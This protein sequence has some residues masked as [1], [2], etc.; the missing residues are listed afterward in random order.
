MLLVPTAPAP[1][2]DAITR[3]QTLAAANDAAGLHAMADDK[4]LDPSVR[5]VAHLRRQ[6]AL[7][8]RRGDH[9]A[10]ER[11]DKIAERVTPAQW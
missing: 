10:A 2:V 9:L 8:R 11:C 6:S 1:L 7:A 3:L 5:R 4:T